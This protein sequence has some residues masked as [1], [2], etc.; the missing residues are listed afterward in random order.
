MVVAFLICGK[1]A[2]IALLCQI[3]IVDFT[4]QKIRNQD[5]LVV[6]A[7][8]AAILFAQWLH[9]TDPVHIGLAFAAALIL[10]VLLL[11]FWM[12][13]KVGAGDVKFLAVAPLIT[14]GENLFYFAIGLLIAAA[15]TAL[16]IRNP[17]LLPEGLFR[18]YIQ[19]LERKRVVPF[20]VPISAALI[21]VLVLQLTSIVS[22]L[23][24]ISQH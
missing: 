7:L 5:V 14:G 12:L 18:H 8:A 19:H 22:E 3:A 10:F 15:V 1:L 20:G 13:G 24:R 16:I 2:L 6:L 9:G 23:A 17:I 21:V 4:E 11:P